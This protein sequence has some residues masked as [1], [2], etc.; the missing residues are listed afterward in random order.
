[1]GCDQGGGNPSLAQISSP[2]PSCSSP[3]APWMLFGRAVLMLR[4]GWPE[5]NRIKLGLCFVQPLCKRLGEVALTGINSLVF[6]T[7]R[8]GPCVPKAL[9]GCQQPP[10]LC[11]YSEAHSTAQTQGCSGAAHLFVPFFQSFLLTPTSISMPTFFRP[12]SLLMFFVVFFLLTLTLPLSISLLSASCCSAGLSGPL[13][14]VIFPISDR[15]V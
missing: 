10:H 6:P 9:R 5:T 8:Q 11:S 3:G 13:D 4:D 14:A 1:M 15:Y 7:L 12:G 2:V